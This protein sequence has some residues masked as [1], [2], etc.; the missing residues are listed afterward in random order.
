MSPFPHPLQMVGA[1]WVA[2]GTTRS[3]ARPDNAVED[4]LFGIGGCKRGA[5]L[6]E[7]GASM[8]QSVKPSR[9]TAVDDFN[10]DRRISWRSEEYG[11]G[12]Q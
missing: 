12:N 11:K 6:G 2:S 7:V 9:G 8:M 3:D 10:L 1:K 4:D 5:I